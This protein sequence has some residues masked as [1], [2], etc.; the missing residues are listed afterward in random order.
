MRPN[1]I[2][3]VG[4][5]PDGM[6]WFQRLHTEL[7]AIGNMCAQ[8]PGWVWVFGVFAVLMFVFHEVNWYYLA[9]LYRYSGGWPQCKREEQE[10][11]E[12]RRWAPFWH[13]LV[14]LSAAGMAA[15]AAWAEPLLVIL[16]VIL[17]YR[18]WRTNVKSVTRLAE[19]L[20]YRLPPRPMMTDAEWEEA[21]HGWDA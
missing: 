9:V 17:A 16:S 10:Y 1:R 20:P 14:L 13:R 19:V 7:S 2:R 4:R 3:Q 8:V 6:D 18:A 15:A 12:G 11:Q 21:L 5:I